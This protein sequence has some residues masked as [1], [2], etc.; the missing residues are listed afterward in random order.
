LESVPADASV[1]DVQEL[2][3]IGDQQMVMVTGASSQLGVFLLPRL[4]S[5]GFHVT[6]LSRS[7]PQVP[8]RVVE[9]LSWAHPDFGVRN[10]DRP[11]S[12]APASVNHLVSCGPID[13]AIQLIDR[14]PRLQR[15]VAF[16][17]SSVLSKEH[18]ADNEER[19]HIA[20]I[21]RDELLLK[22]LCKERNLPL[23][24]L[25]PTLIYGCGRDRNISLLARTGSRLGVIPVSGNAN[26]L[27]QPVHAD[28][29]AGL[30]VR[31]LVND[32]EIDLESEACGGSTLS[33]REM[34]EKIAASGGSRVRVLRLPASFLTAAIGA[35]SL[36]P[37]WKG[38][39]AEMIRRQSHDLVFDDF[40]LRKVLNYDPR[41]FDP[42][43]EDFKLPEY[44]RKLQLP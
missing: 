29:L 15:A 22:K 39:N 1:T 40:A 18:S 21:G 5:A 36:L 19:A 30:A 9:G 35:L 8:M 24:L 26:G 14:H 23:L 25:R 31:A 43:L 7:G 41:A 12:H 16:S 32:K 34:V 10:D 33:Y 27:R 2:S 28:D 3:G 13:L 44:A 37:P 4:L 38:L 17:T 6:A 11:Q 42:T 20:T